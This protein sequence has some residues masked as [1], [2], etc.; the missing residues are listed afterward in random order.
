MALLAR[1]KRMLVEDFPDQTEWISKLIQPLNEFNDN[2]SNAMNRNLTFQDNFL[3][4]FKTIEVST[5][6]QPQAFKCTLPVK[7][8]GVIKINIVEIAGNP[9]PPSGA[10]DIVWEYVN[11]NINLTSVTGLTVGKRYNLT[12]LVFGG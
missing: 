2:V 12:L 10:V 9:T 4:Q 11:G 1:F 3:A 5:T 6:S 7:P 8:V